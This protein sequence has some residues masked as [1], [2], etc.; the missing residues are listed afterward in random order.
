MK[1]EELHSETETFT[2]EAMSWSWSVFDLACS[3]NPIAV[4]SCTTRL[5][6]F[7]GVSS[8][9]RDNQYGLQ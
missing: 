2:Y 1:E 7:G 3:L 9:V 6:S 4:R 8:I 5:S